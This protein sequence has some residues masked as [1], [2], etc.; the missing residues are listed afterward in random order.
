VNVYGEIK[1]QDTLRQLKNAEEW[2]REHDNDP[3]LLLTLGRLSL[4]NGLWGKAR[5]YLEQLL[6]HSPSPEAFR[7]LAEAQ[8]QLGDREAALRCHRQGLLLATG[9]PSLPL[10]PASR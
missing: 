7:L 3:V 4:L 10:L 8:E 5:S 2:L 6:A 1:P 9:Q